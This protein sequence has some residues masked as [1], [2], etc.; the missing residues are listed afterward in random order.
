MSYEEEK[1]AIWKWYEQR[2][3]EYF[4]T[5]IGPGRDSDANAQHQEDFMEYNRR[6]NAL[7]EKY[8]V[9]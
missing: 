4:N 7:D 2:T 5:P 6:L 8:G 9:K 1:E 3:R